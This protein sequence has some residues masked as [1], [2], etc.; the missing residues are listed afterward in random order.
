MQYSNQQHIY[1]SPS[2]FIY[3]CMYVH[4]VDFIKF[5]LTPN[6]NVFTISMASSPDEDEEEAAAAAV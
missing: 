2:L 6:L 3:V 5:I 1:S 4:N